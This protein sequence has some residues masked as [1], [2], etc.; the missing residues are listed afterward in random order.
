MDVVGGG[1]APLPVADDPEAAEVIHVRRRQEGHD[2]EQRDPA[3]AI[4]AVG[5]VV[6]IQR[7]AHR[8]HVEPLRAGGEILGI[9]RGDRTVEG[10]SGK[11]GD[12]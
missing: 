4:H 8:S 9:R 7:A 1:A 11:D 12:G 10:G 5:E 3:G 2:T 6:E